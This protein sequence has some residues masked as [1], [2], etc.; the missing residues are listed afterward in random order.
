[1]FCNK[2]WK[3]CAQFLSDEYKIK[4]KELFKI[5]TQRSGEQSNIKSEYFQISDMAVEIFLF[6]IK[7]LDYTCT[8][9]V[10]R[11]RM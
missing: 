3:T 8:Y 6:L 1:M 11:Q 9:F 4:H 10:T 2:L 5:W 7:I